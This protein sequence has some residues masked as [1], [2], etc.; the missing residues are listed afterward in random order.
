MEY[1]LKFFF[2]QYPTHKIIVVLTSPRQYAYYP[3]WKGFAH[4]GIILAYNSLTASSDSDAAAN[5]SIRGGIL[6]HEFGHWMGLQHVFGETT[7][8]TGDEIT[9]TSTYSNLD[10]GLHSCSQAKCGTGA[11]QRVQNWM[12]VSTTLDRRIHDLT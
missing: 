2:P 1:A 11:M 7:C 8:G 10:P 9:D 6:V 12:S 5:P 4:D 3:S